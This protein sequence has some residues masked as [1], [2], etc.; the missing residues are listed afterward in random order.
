MKVKVVPNIFR[1]ALGALVL[2][3]INNSV[4]AD[5]IIVKGAWLP[6]AAPVAR[7]MAAYMDISNHGKQTSFI[8]RVT[9]PQFEKVE[10]H[11]M[12]HKGGMMQME[13]QDKLEIPAGNTVSLEPGGFHM[14]LFKPKQWYKD[15]SK[16]TLHI[17][18]D[19]KETF[20]IIAPVIK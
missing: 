9:S 16:I 8:T 17:T 10:I 2:L 4:V 12:S 15:G 11:S 6:E 20:K 18:L 7:V 19:G 1:K 5:H 3:S 13:K 14:M